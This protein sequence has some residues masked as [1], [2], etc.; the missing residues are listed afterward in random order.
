MQHGM[1]FVSA[2]YRL[3][4]PSTGLDIVE[5]VKSLFAFLS[6][7]L[8]E[9]LPE[10]CQ[11]DS[12]AIVTSGCSGG[13]YVSRLAAV[14]AVPR[15][16]AQINLFGMG[17]QMLSDRLVI[18]RTTK[19]PFSLES[20]QDYLDR[21]PQVISEDTEVGLSL[22][23]RLVMYLMDEAKYLDYLLACPRISKRLAPLAYEQRIKAVPK[24]SV[25]ALP[26]LFI[27]ALYPPTVFV[28]GD[29]DTLVL[30]GDSQQDHAILRDKGVPTDL[31]IVE[32]AHHMFFNEWPP[33]PGTHIMPSSVNAVQKAFEFALSHL[34]KT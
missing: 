3:L 15:P 9:L 26:E 7:R 11:V 13:G 2:D 8:T 1:I 18:S 33:G 25:D 31:I 27:D 28:H 5:D 22:R 14:H 23:M 6:T 19:L 32:D 24:G 10:G 17:A 30:V 34:A 4:C 12:K 21:S 29:I 20:A 16:A